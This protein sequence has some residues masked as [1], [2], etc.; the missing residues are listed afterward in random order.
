MNKSQLA[1]KRAGIIMKVNCGLMTAAQAARELNVSRK[2]YYKWEKKGLSALLGS[3]TDQQAGRP[4]RTEDKEQELL[5]QQ[6]E[7]AMKENALLERR[8]F[9]KDLLSDIK[10]GS[11]N[12]AKKK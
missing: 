3:V 7:Q 6:L 4:D 8:M 10:P 5:K 9:L 1:R 12:R 2:T 11:G